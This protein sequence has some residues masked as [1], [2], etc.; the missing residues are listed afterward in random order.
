METV[1]IVIKNSEGA[2]F[3]GETWVRNLGNA[4]RYNINTLASLRMAFNDNGVIFIP[5][6]FANWTPE[7]EC[8]IFEWS[9][10]LTTCD[11]RTTAAFDL[12]ENAQ[13]L[14]MR[15]LINDPELDKVYGIFVSAIKKIFNV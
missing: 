8:E 12:Y 1:N 9:E 15:G 10:E 13:N 2:F 7:A 11:I 3:T 6:F 14:A 4:K 5:E